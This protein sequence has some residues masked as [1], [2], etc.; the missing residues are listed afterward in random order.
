MF[1]IILINFNL[2]ILLLFISLINASPEK[3]PI[4]TSRLCTKM[5]KIKAGDSCEGTALKYG[6]SIEQLYK[7][8]H[9]NAEKCKKL[10]IFII[11]FIERILYGAY[12]P[13]SCSSDKQCRKGRTC[14][15]NVCV[16]ERCYSSDQCPIYW[17]CARIMKCLKSC[18]NID[19]CKIGWICNN[20]GVCVQEGCR[21][22]AGESCVRGRCM[23]GWIASRL[24]FE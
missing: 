20:E 12:L 3:Q 1:K 7:I 21:C 4:I 6:I 17:N 22:R 23:P 5:H 14:T 24:D 16:P 2:I 11:I 18:Q 10:A 19:E 9:W 15:M 8:N 13:K